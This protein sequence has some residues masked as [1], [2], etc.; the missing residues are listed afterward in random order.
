MCVRLHGIPKGRD[1]RFSGG[2]VIVSLINQM[3]QDLEKRQV[4]SESGSSLPPG[5]HSAEQKQGGVAGLRKSA[6]LLGGLGVLALAAYGW[7]TSAPVG[8][9]PPVAEVQSAT[10]PPPAVPAEQPPG[11]SPAAG[12][13]AP[14]ATPSPVPA[15]LA[16]VTPKPAEKKAEPVLSRKELAAQ[17]RREAAAAKRE[18]KKQREEARKAGASAVSVSTVPVDMSAERAEAAYREA[19][20]AFSLGRH[21]ELVQAAR[22]AL[23]I[24]PG[25]VAARQLLVRHFMEQRAADDARRELR[26]GLQ[27][28][29][30]QMLWSTLLVRLELERGDATS[31]RQVVDRALPYADAQADFQSLAGAVAQR[32]GKPADAANFYRS[33]LRLKPTDGRSWVGLGMSLE[34]EGH[35]PEAQE[36]FRRALASDGLSADLQSLAQRKLR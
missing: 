16:E 11:A 34:A 28:Q 26:E 17:K 8:P 36:A 1:A 21:G 20:T 10:M 6:L 12:V 9:V 35:Q 24:Q 25:H 13:V 4:N 14:A 18:A 5:V 29:P 19:L 15:P 30:G 22:Q 31:A 23:Q 32:Q 7:K 33:A 2:E 27:Q 3:L